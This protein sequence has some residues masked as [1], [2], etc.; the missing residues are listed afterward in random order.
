MFPFRWTSAKTP[1][2]LHS[3]SSFL[4]ARLCAVGPVFC[5]LHCLH[6]NA[7]CYV[8]VPTVWKGPVALHAKSLFGNPDGQKHGSFN[9]I[10]SE[11]FISNEGRVVQWKDSG[12][13]L[14]LQYFFLIIIPA[15]PN[16]KDW[17]HPSRRFADTPS[18]LSLPFLHHMPPPLTGHMCCSA[19]L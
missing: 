9:Q 19:V 17:K 16:W 18:H 14:F 8:C 13:N 11:T 7:N 12:T 1:E 2:S 3:P 10:P 5:S 4:K 6:Q 15:H